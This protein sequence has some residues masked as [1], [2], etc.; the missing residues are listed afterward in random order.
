MHR[1]RRRNGSKK[2]PNVILRP[3]TSNAAR[4]D[5]TRAATP[6][7]EEDRELGEYILPSICWKRSYAV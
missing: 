6:F 2:I 1:S 7:D 5:R 4:E 3:S